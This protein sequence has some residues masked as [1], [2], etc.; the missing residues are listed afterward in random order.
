MTEEQSYQEFI[1]DR[2][3]ED[4]YYN[5]DFGISHSNDEAMF[6][7]KYAYSDTLY[8]KALLI[9]K[10]YQGIRN[11]NFNIRLPRYSDTIILYGVCPINKYNEIFSSI[12]TKSKNVVSTRTF[13][14]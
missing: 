7:I 3:L 6:K 1:T 11:I 5:G 10:Q 14:K 13:G 4:H 9:V 2:I 8:D 12:N